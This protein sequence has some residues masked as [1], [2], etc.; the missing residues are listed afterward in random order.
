MMFRHSTLI[1]GS[2]HPFIIGGH[3][4]VMETLDALHLAQETV[5]IE[6]A[7]KARG[8]HIQKESTCRMRPLRN[9]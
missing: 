2:G 8:Q 3:Q 1:R 5:P 9:Y 7:W 4:T 6:P